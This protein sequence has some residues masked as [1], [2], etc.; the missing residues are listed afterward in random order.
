MSTLL[1]MM[2]SKCLRHTTTSKRKRDAGT[3]ERHPGETKKDK[4]SEDEQG[5]RGIKEQIS[6]KM[7]MIV[8][9]RIE[10]K[11]MGYL[12]WHQKVSMKTEM[13]PNKANCSIQP[14]Q[15][16]NSIELSFSVC[17]S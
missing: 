9:R 6:T 3:Q 16:S 14:H 7:K 10:R 8:S 2:S 1:L 13:N 11:K 5:M 17:G 12:K 15:E 4:K